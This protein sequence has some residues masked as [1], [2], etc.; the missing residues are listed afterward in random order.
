[1]DKNRYDDYSTESFNVSD[2]TPML[3]RTKQDSRSVNTNIYT[4]YIMYNYIYF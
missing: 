1:M 4:M 2:K 3:G